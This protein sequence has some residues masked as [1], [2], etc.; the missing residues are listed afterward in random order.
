[1]YCIY[2]QR[3]I[4]RFA[5]AEF[6][7]WEKKERKKEAGGGVFFDRSLSLSPVVSGFFDNTMARQPAAGRF[8][9]LVREREVREREREKGFM[10]SRAISP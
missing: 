10:Y 3:W 5:L 9:S 7:L 1:M 2:T 8:F 6:F 4:K